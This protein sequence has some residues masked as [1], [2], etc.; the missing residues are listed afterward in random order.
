MLACE[1]A[2]GAQHCLDA[3]VAW[4]KQRMQFARPIGS[5][6]AIQH[7]C[8]EVLLEVASAQSAAHFASWAAE[9][10]DDLPLAAAMAKSFCDEAYLRAAQENLHIHGGVG[11]TWEAEP[12]LHLKRAKASETLLGPPAF[13]RARIAQALGF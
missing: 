13:Q 6:Q 12:H 10:D 8:A 2:G 5:F 9:Q 4:A 3:A 11:F 1:S 7:K